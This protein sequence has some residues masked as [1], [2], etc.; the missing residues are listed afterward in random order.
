MRGILTKL[1]GSKGERTAAD[2][3]RKQGMKVLARQYRTSRGEIDLICRDGDQLVFVEVKT[4]RSDAAG[5]PAEAITYEKQKKLTELALAYLKRR[6]LLEH[7]ARFDVV[8][9]LWPEE[10]TKPEIE[11]YRN[12]FPPVGFGQMF[13]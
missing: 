13:S 5:N 3:L 10:S 1:L 9:I 7:R 6:K 2:Y 11:H 4:R 12:A 8:S